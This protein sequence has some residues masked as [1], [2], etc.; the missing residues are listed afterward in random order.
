MMLEQYVGAYGRHEFTV[1]DV[2][3]EGIDDLSAVTWVLRV[4]GAAGAIAD[5]DCTY[6]Q[7]TA[8]CELSAEDSARLAPGFHRWFLIAEQ[9]GQDD[10]IAGEGTLKM[11]SYPQPPAA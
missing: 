3:T 8:I 11:L 4:L 9:A 7:P 6:T 5:F 1:D 10:I 2:T